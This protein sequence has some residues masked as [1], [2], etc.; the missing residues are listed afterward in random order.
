M[1]TFFLRDRSFSIRFRLYSSKQIQT[2]PQAQSALDR[3]EAVFGTRL[4]YPERFEEVPVI[5]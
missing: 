1:P 5:F 4:V 2:D 3:A